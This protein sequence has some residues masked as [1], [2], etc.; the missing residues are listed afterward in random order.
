MPIAIIHLSDLHYR[1]GPKDDQ[2]VVFTA[3]FADLKRQVAHL[4]SSQ[5]YLAL[6]GDIVQCGENS[7]LYEKFAEKF[8]RELEKLNIP[9]AH[10]ICVPGNHDISIKQIDTIIVDHDRVV[11]QKLDEQ[12]F[13]SYV[14][15]S[16][17]VFTEKFSQYRSFENQF[18]G[19]GVAQGERI[20]G[21]GWEIADD[22]G[23]YC[24]NSAL[25]CSGA[26]ELRGKRLTDKGRLSIDTH[27]FY[28]WNLSCKAKV[29]ILIMH[30]PLNWL[31]EWAQKTLTA[32]L[33][34]DFAICLSG[35][36]H[37]QSTLHLVSQESSLVECSAPPFFT[38]KHDEPGYSIISI[39]SKRGVSCISYRQWAAKYGTFV[40]S[41]RFRNNEKGLS[42]IADHN[43]NRDCQLKQ[44]AYLT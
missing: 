15:N 18:A 24:L 30:H 10:R 9:K 25:C 38:D 4:G 29:K 33:R 6:S 42:K 14:S 32:K 36:A 26:L 17:N 37:D 21:S 8:D 35:H 23:I 12:D 27:N 5:I 7:L 34:K 31:S 20:T 2:A 40:P 22:I 28:G 11:G 16:S 19:F 44:P 1:H 3:F 13:N 43:A 39:G 41:A